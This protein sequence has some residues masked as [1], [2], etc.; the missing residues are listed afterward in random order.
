[1]GL[2]TTTTLFLFFTLSIQMASSIMTTL[3]LGGTGATGSLLIRQLLEK[4]QNV[5]AIVRSKE[6]L[7]AESC[8]KDVVFDIHKLTIIEGTLLDMSDNEVK[9]CV[10]GCDAVVSCLGHNMT[11]KGIYG[12]PRKLV[13][14]SMKRVCD[15]VQQ[16]SSAQ[17]I[18]VILMGSDGVASPYGSDDVRSM[19]DRILLGI[20]RALLPPLV[21]NEEAA[22]HVC[23]TVG[24]ETPNLQW[25]I[26]RPS[27]L[28]DADVSK[29][30]IVPKP[31]GSLFGAAET[32]RANVAAFMCELI[33]N[34]ASWKKWMFQLPVVINA[35][36]EQAPASK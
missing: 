29:Y 14:D 36:T 1:M 25:V 22:E 26:V 21:D 27:D 11:M 6:K 30:E 7:I 12:K 32:S 16:L 20:L 13:K 5:R 10:D 15:I 28:I 8:L 33:L 35:V 3:V 4:N 9:A 34:D 18:K 23:L 17:T 24:K 31:T 2:G 19:G